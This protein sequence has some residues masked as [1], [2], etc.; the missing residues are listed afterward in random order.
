MQRA[1]A[2]GHPRQSHPVGMTNKVEAVRELLRCFGEAV[3]SLPVS[4]AFEYL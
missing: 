4:V 1:V 3:S 2:P